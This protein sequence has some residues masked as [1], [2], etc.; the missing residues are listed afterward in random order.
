M[1]MEQAYRVAK[2]RRLSLHPLPP[3]PRPRHLPFLSLI[4]ALGCREVEPTPATG[5]RRS[6]LYKFV[7]QK[8][9]GK[10]S[11]PSQI[12]NNAQ[13][14]LQEWP[15]MK[16]TQFYLSTPKLQMYTVQ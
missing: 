5:K 13:L 10:K 8:A 1:G 7:F 4:V 6:F 11:S 16:G 9:K 15:D 12:T 14:I 3:P 2:L